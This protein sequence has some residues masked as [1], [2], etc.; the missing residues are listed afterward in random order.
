MPLT[1]AGSTSAPTW[2]SRTPRTATPA[3]DPALPE[4]WCETLPNGRVDRLRRRGHRGPAGP[5]RRLPASRTSWSP[6][7]STPST[8]SADD[9]KG[10]GG[11]GA[12]GAGRP[13]DRAGARGCGHHGVLLGHRQLDVRP[14]RGRRQREHRRDRLRPHPPRLQPQG[15]GAGLD[16]REP[17]GHQASGGLGRP[18]RRQPQP[19]AVRVRPAPATWSTSARPCS[20]SRT[21]TPTRPPR[22]SS[23]TRWP[24]P[25]R[26]G[27]VVLGD[28]EDDVPPRP[29]DR[30][31][32]PDRGE[33][34]WR[35]HAGQP[36]RRDAALE[37]RRRHRLHE[38][39]WPA[40]RP[41]RPRR[42]PRARSP[43]GRPPTPSRSPTRW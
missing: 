31:R 37:D 7:S 32:R 18:V 11:C 27:N 40:R 2:S 35:V 9:L 24:T 20:S 26:P 17:H 25:R 34:R 1:P 43:T 15:A 16:R 22:T 19:A 21:T 10:P 38:P 41:G 42:R 23:T 5:R 30:R 12:D 33:P 8:S 28:I 14:D 29:P 3:G 39:G 4:T 13:G 36:D 6:T